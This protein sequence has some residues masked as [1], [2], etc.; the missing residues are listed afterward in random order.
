M[1]GKIYGDTFTLTQDLSIANSNIVVIVKESQTLTLNDGVTLTI[2]SIATLTNN[3]TLNNSGTIINF[4]TLNNTSVL[5]NAGSII[6]KGT[7]N[8]EVGGKGTVT[9]KITTGGL[10]EGTVG[11]AYSQTF[12]ATNKTVTWQSSNTGVATVDE[13]GKVTA[14]RSGTAD[15][16]A[17]AADDSGQSAACTVKVNEKAEPQPPSYSYY[18]VALYRLY[19]TNSGEHSYTASRTERLHLVGLGW[20]DED[21]AFGQ[22][23]PAV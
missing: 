20:R 11:T 6:N 21:I 14:V 18:T 3:G 16:T 13:N 1:R 5:D 7:L 9:P 4:G 17:T 10:P 19:N 12:N 15:I 2:P 23:A 8:G 22:G